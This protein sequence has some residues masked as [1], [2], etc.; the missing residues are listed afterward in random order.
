MLFRVVLLSSVFA[1][2]II[3]CG[4]ADAELAPRAPQDIA[5]QIA[6][7]QSAG[8]ASTSDRFTRNET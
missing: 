5:Q 6:A 7:T 1:C 8:S 3:G 4:D 2:L